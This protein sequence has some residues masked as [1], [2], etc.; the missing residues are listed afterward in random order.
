[1]VAKTRLDPRLIVRFGD[2]ADVGIVS[3]FIDE[4]WKSGHILARDQ[5]LFEY[6]YL[7]K[8]S[9]LNFVLAFEPEANELIAILGFASS[10]LNLS[11]VST[12]MWKAREDLKFRKFRAGVAVYNF[13]LKQINPRSI[14]SNTISPNTIDFYKFL[15]FPCFLMDH[16][17]YVNSHVNDF[18]IIVNPPLR[19]PLLPSLETPIACLS[20]LDDSS[21]LQRAL[22]EIPFAEGKKDSYYLEHRYFRNPRFKYHVFEVL[23]KDKS[24]GLIV[25]RRQFVNGGSC[26]RIIDAIG[27]LPCLVE[28]F[29]SLINEMYRQG[30]EYIDLVCWGL[31]IDAIQKT[32]LVYRRKYPECIVPELFSPFVPKNVDRWLFTNN[33]D[34]E[35]IYKGDGDQDRPN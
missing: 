10:N 26:I 23:V 32:G 3:K 18:K 35:K 28:A 30:D 14:F 21:D 19:I 15:K 4:H 33:P 13:L 31:N 6:M 5:E 27:D 22:R 9:R 16:F 11:R 7:E 29:P 8:N 25:Y 12:S 20:A 24:I 1:M 34:N 17:V 2:I